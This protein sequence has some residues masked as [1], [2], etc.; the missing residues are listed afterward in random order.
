ML[1][2]V[3]V[4]LATP[5]PVPTLDGKPLSAN[6]AQRTFRVPMRF[7]KVRAF[8]VAQLKD[9]PD[10]TLTL[11]GAGGRRVLTIANRGKG[12]PWLKATV[13]EHET[14]TVIDVVPVLR[15]EETEVIGRARPLVQFIIGRSA[16]ADE[17]AAN[18]DHTEQ[19]RQ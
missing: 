1:A 5:F 10:V 12:D 8:Y 4:V 17:A 11:T 6:E 3:L 19:I 9:R 2:L 13:S 15:M 7:Q 16:A 14:E 18:I